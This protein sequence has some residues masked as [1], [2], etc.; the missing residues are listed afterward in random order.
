ML[1]GGLYGLDV[2]RWRYFHEKVVCLLSPV[3]RLWP[4][5][6]Y[7]LLSR[8]VWPIRSGGE[9]C[10]SWAIVQPHHA[11]ERIN[12]TL[13]DLDGLRREHDHDALHWPGAAVAKKQ[14]TKVNW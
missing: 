5:T 9:Y 1:T 3:R 13:C 8:V 4:R 2:L 11:V 6:L 7:G 12:S 14:H 10:Q